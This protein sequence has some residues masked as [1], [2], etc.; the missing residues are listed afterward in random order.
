MCNPHDLNHRSASAVAGLDREITGM[1]TLLGAC[2]TGAQCIA[3]GKNNISPLFFCV[4]ELC[5]PNMF[6]FITLFCF[7]FINN[8]LVQTL[9]FAKAHRRPHRPPPRKKTGGALSPFSGGKNRRAGFRS[10]RAGAGSDGKG[11]R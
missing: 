2:P 9:R 1:D 11:R 4:C 3:V 10:Q 6:F 8:M 5:S 7:I